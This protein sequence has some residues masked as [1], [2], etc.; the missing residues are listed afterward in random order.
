MAET[1]WA[2]WA[3]VKTAVG[4]LGGTLDTFSGAPLVF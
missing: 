3:M 1:F 2:I 4:V